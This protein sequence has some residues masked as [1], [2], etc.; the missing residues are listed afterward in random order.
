M[1]INEREFIM[2]KIFKQ[3]KTFNFFLK[4]NK[5]NITINYT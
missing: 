1:K 4:L 3:L 5:F 2:S